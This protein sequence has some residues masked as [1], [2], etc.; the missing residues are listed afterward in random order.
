MNRQ[1]TTTI[2]TLE[3]LTITPQA[4]SAVN[5]LAGGLAVIS[6]LTVVTPLLVVYLVFRMVSSK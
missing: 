3:P 6:V 5:V 4:K 2:N 1:P